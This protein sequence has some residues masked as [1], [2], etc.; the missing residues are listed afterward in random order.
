MGKRERMKETEDYDE[1]EGKKEVKEFAWMP[2]GCSP[3]ADGEY[4]KKAN[5]FL[6]LSNIFYISLVHLSPF[7]IYVPKMLSSWELV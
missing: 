1:S 4:G 6:I 5:T 3:L 7:T 2:A